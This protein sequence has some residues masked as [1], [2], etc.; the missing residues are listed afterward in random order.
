MQLH[1][2]AGG[3]VYFKKKKQQKTDQNVN[4]IQAEKQIIEKILANNINKK[5]LN[6][7]SNNEM[8]YNFKDLSQISQAPNL[9]KGFKNKFLKLR[10]WN[11]YK[12]LSLG[13]LSIKY[14]S[15]QCLGTQTVI[16]VTQ[17]LFC[18]SQ[19]S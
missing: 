14:V 4:L 2:N 16:T 12:Q 19:R 6:F 15:A 3:K 18:A 5:Q 13:R 1:T 8:Q 9:D 10:F 11:I 17:G 7:V